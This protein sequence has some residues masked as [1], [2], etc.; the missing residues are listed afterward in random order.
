MDKSRESMRMLFF[1]RKV[2]EGCATLINIPWPM[3]MAVAQTQQLVLR[4]MMVTLPAS[5]FYHDKPEINQH[6]L[7]QHKRKNRVKDTYVLRPNN[8]NRN[9]Y[10]AGD[11][12]V[13]SVKVTSDKPS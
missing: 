9:P 3:S 13:V 1:T 4:E 11:T 6:L 12:I 10:S 7:K 2:V 5:V 8:S